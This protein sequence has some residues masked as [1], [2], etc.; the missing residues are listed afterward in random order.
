MR[1][2]SDI[3]STPPPDMIEELVKA[4]PAPPPTSRIGRTIV[5]I[6]KRVGRNARCPCGSGK[7]SKFCH[8]N[9]VLRDV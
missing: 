7:R 1:T 2:E 4:P 9:A 6:G 3:V 5:N 8:K